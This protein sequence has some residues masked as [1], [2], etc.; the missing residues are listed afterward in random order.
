[1]WLDSEIVV[2]AESLVV[3]EKPKAKN[4]DRVRLSSSSGED[5]LVGEKPTTEN[6]DRVRFSSSPGKDQDHIELAL[7]NQENKD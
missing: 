4:P 3:G 6:P 5:Y 2:G 7:Q 1:L